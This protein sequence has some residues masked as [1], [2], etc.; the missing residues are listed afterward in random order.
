[1]ERHLLQKAPAGRANKEGSSV[2][3]AADQE[4]TAVAEIGPYR[5]MVVSVCEARATEKL[6]I[7]DLRQS[8]QTPNPFVA[9]DLGFVRE[10][11]SPFAGSIF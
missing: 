6:I 10:V 11:A 4:K 5:G 9:T 3:Y 1:M 2:F 8:L 7:I